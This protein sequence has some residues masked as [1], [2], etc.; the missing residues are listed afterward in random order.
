MLNP[1]VNANNVFGLPLHWAL[2]YFELEL[3]ACRLNLEAMLELRTRI[4][5]HY[6]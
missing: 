3:S 6:S 5:I 4:Q 1:L 2:M